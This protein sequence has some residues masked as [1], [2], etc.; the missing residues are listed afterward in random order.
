MFFHVRLFTVLALMDEKLLFSIQELLLCRG[1]VLSVQRISNY[2]AQLGH[3]YL[4]ANL[5]CLVYI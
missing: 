3:G 2:L 4:I 5:A 1:H